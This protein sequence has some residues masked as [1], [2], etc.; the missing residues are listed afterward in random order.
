MGNHFAL[1]EQTNMKFR[2]F[3][4]KIRRS[5]FP[6]VVSVTLGSALT[7]MGLTFIVFTE[8]YYIETFRPVWEYASP[9]AWAVLMVFAGVTSIIASLW[10]RRWAP[11]PLV[12]QT[13]VWGL[14]AV[15][16]AIGSTGGGVPSAPI[17]YTA[18]TWICLMLV[19]IYSFEAIESERKE[20]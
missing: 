12:L 4:S 7:V 6:E 9:E 11:V 13:V 19:L 8:P 14:L 1:R 18:V 15:L 2:K 16:T 17:I 3:R 10:S 5:T 20:R